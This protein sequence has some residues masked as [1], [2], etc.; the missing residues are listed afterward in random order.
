MT[1][2]ASWSCLGLK[3]C[4]WVG[5]PLVSGCE[6][7]PNSDRALASLGTIRC[8]A[9]GVLRDPAVVL[10]LTSQAAFRERRDDPVLMNMKP[11]IRDM[12][13]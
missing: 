9:A 6:G 10:N 7:S 8:K 3:T 4:F 13:P 5:N 12:I 2:N 1:V 11:D